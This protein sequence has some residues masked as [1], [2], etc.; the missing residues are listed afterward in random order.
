MNLASR[1]SNKVDERFIKESLVNQALNHDYQFNGVKTVNVYS[2]PTAPLNDY[3]RTGANRYGTPVDLQNNIQ[4]LTLTR[5]RSFAFVI[6]RGD[7]NQSQMVMDAGKAL[8][9]EVREVIVPEFDKYVLWTLGKA[10]SDFGNNVTTAPDKTNAYKLFLDAQAVLG[11][12]NVPDAGR[13]AFCSYD[14]AN[15]LKQDPAFMIQSEK[16]KDAVNKGVIGEVDGVKVV[17]VPSTRLPAGAHMILTHPIAACGPK[18]LEDYKV[19]DNPPGISGW[20]VEGRIIYD[21]F[22]M[23]QKASAVFLLG[24][25]VTGTFAPPASSTYGTGGYAAVTNPTGNPKTSGWYELN[26][27]TGKYVKTTDTT[28]TSGKTYYIKT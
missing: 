28:V 13:I 27:S 22:V 25:A 3:S 14:Y 23:D 5:D 1:Y 24:F 8:S 11:N 7:K 20:L 16:S 17:K 19:H 26:A 21:C 12:A 15:F 10:A 2:V 6:D 4:T 18:Q 9:R